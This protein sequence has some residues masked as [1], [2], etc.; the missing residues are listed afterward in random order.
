[1][2]NSKENNWETWREYWKSC[3]IEL[4]II[5]KIVLMLRLNEEKNIGSF[6]FFCTVLCIALYYAYFD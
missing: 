2:N 6:K 4:A 1:M 5:Y 3:S